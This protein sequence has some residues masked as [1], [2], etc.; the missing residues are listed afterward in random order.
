M[1]KEQKFALWEK[2]TEP[3]EEFE[4][5]L[6]NATIKVVPIDYKGIDLE[7]KLI[8]IGKRGE[9]GEIE[10]VEWSLVSSQ[11]EVVNTSEVVEF[12]KGTLETY[13]KKVEKIQSVGES[14]K[15][16]SVALLWPENGEVRGIILRN[17]YKSGVALQVRIGKVI[18]RVVI[19]LWYFRYIHSERNMREKMAEDLEKLDEFFERW[20]RLRELPP[21]YGEIPNIIRQATEHLKKVVIDKK[22]GEKRVIHYGS[23]IAEKGLEAPNIEEAL[24][25]MFRAGLEISKAQYWKRKLDKMVLRIVGEV[26]KNQKVKLP[27]FF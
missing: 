2:A 9:K 5:K 21:T 8:L 6:L 10:R 19:P 17:A 23:K 27:V 15:E 26:A 4:D 1:K 12:L 25:E 13:G 11:Y 24:A 18:G 22:T 20:N 16:I 14:Y 7:R 3:I